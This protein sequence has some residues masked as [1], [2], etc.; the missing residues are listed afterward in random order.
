MELDA[1]GTLYLALT[2]TDEKE[3]AARYDWQTRAGLQVNK[4]TVADARR[5]EPVITEK[6]R[7]ALHFPGDIQVDN[8]RLL[9]ALVIS[10]R[11][12]GVRLV[13]GTNVESVET[14]CGRI[15]GVV[16]ARGLVSA[17]RVVL[18]AGAWTSFIS[19]AQPEMPH[20]KIEPVRGQMVCL[21]T[22]T[23]TA[24]HILY[25][26]RG[27]VVPRLDGRVL[28]G[29]TT[30]A[31]GFAPEV[32]AAG[33]SQILNHALEM[34]PLLGTAPINAPGRAS[35]RERRTI[36]L[37]LTLRDR[38]FVLRHRPLSQRYPLA[39]ITGVD[40]EAILSNVISPAQP[41][42]SPPI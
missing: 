29:S 1:T 22:K 15:A 35:D 27:Y 18:A 23:G 32:T 19:A 7:M 16:T 37:Y 31:V 40:Q 2:E 39:P 8:R 12:L 34:A 33:I 13:N 25:S 11:S 30:E 14:D 5:L 24:R 21:Q 38:R 6:A 20:V 3:V 28:A 41:V 9:K 10:N 17:P 26:P 36:C 4:L 42:C